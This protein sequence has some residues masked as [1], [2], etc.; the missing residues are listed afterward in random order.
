MN[1]ALKLIAT[2]ALVVPLAIYLSFMRATDSR[3]TPWWEVYIVLGVLAALIMLN[4]S[5]F[6]A[7]LRRWR[8]ED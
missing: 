1:S 6:R 5:L 7:V 4:V 8:G 3:P 2:A